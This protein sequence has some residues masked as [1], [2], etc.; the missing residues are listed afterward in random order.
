MLSVR[1]TLDPTFF[2][3]V[4]NHPE[5][6]PHVGPNDGPLDVS[7]VVTNPANVCLRNEH[8]G[9]LCEGYGNGTYEVHS[10]FLPEG[11]G[12]PSL[13]AAMDT[14]RYLFTN[15]DCHQIL[16]KFPKSNEA[17]IKFGT[18]AGYRP[19]FERDCEVFG[20]TIY[21]AINIEHWAANDQWL[22]EKGEWFHDRLEA[23][24]IA[25]GSVLPIHPED[26]AHNRAVGAV[27]H[28]CF[29]GNAV[30]AVNFY[31]QW[32]RLAGYMPVQLVSLNPIVIDLHDAVIE[33]GNQDME[34][35]LCRLGAQ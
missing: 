13:Q 6:R 5:V 8:G 34:I 33:V 20:P 12:G 2:N 19:L 21:M 15:T 16:G 17:I 18:K 23:A 9:F 22:D 25:A 30:K 11:R 27:V 24:K 3:Y 32:A 35:L 26:P 10:Q 29:A 14:E 31:N 4:V 7:D 1:R 28:M